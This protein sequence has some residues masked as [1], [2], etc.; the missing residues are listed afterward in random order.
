MEEETGIHGKCDSCGQPIYTFME[1]NIEIYNETGMCG[2]CATGE[3]ATY[4][5][6]L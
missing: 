6:E 3:A 2:A 1:N 4:I 5:D